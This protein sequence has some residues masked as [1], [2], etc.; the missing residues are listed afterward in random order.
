VIRFSRKGA[1]APGDVT[2]SAG[3]LFLVGC[4]LGL[5]RHAILERRKY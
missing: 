5:V 3:G 2:I 4:A 1:F